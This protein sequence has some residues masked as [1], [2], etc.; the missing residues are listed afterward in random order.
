MTAGHKGWYLAWWRVLQEWGG[1][2][3][4]LPPLQL[5]TFRYLRYQDRTHVTKTHSLEAWYWSVEGIKLVPKC[6]R[7]RLGAW[8]GPHFVTGSVMTEVRWTVGVG[9]GSAVSLPNAIYS[10][11]NVCS[12]TGQD[13]TE[14]LCTFSTAHRV[15]LIFKLVN[16]LNVWFSHKRGPR[17]VPGIDELT[18]ERYPRV[19]GAG[20]VN[21]PTCPL[22]SMATH[23]YNTLICHRLS[24]ACSNMFFFCIHL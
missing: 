17:L 6:M 11:R 23:G 9:I 1:L 10:K 12:D 7:S 2:M 4:W 22:G 19:Q 24:N 3:I 18:H 16:R 15:S 20:Q 13:F 14:G 21:S 8:W 5:V